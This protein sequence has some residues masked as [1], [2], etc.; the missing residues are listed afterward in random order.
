MHVNNETGA[1]NDIATIAEAVKAKNPDTMFFADGVQAFLRVPFSMNTSKVDYYSVSAHK[2]HGL[3]G[4][5]MLFFRKGTPL[6][7]YLLGGGQESALR[8]GTEN[9]F[10]IL[11]FAEPG[12]FA[13]PCAKTRAYGAAEN[14]SARRA[15]FGKWRA[16]LHARFLC[17]T[18][19]QHG[20]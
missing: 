12:V 1:I 18:H 11:A 13:G 15:A 19:S 9:T 4:T 2:V 17:P 8:S 14:A 3:K 6:K 16:L 5:G 7:A 10:G 20:V